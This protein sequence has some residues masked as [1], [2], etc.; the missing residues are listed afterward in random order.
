MRLRCKECGQG[1]APEAGGVTVYQQ[2]AP[3]EMPAEWLCNDCGR[4]PS[5]N[6]MGY[7]LT[8]IAAMAMSETPG[9]SDYER[10]LREYKA[11]EQE[12]K[13]LR[14]LW[15]IRLLN[16]LCDIP[17]GYTYDGIA[18]W[19][20]C[21]PLRSGGELRFSMTE[22]EDGGESRLGIDLYD[23][24]LPPGVTGPARRTGPIDNGP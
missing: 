2:N 11:L 7:D 17:G 18:S 8:A 9:V 22:D 5:V 6:S 15:E 16:Q 23:G 4:A 10:L 14:E 20:V 24:A 1:P 21:F 19:Q 13:K 12:N 3:G